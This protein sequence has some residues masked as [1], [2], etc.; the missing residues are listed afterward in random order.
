MSLQLTDNLWELKLDSTLD[1]NIARHSLGSFTNPF[2]VCYVTSDSAL[3]VWKQAGT[4]GQAIDFDDSFAHGEIKQ[5]TLNSHLLFQFPLL[6]GDSYELYYFSLP[7]LVEVKLK[8]WQ[9]LGDT[10]DTSIQQIITALESANL[11]NL[12]IN[13]P[14]I[15]IQLQQL[16]A[17]T[18]YLQ[19]LIKCSNDLDGDTSG[20]NLPISLNNDTGRLE[21]THE[22]ETKTVAI[23][24]DSKGN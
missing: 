15:E 10:T 20:V 3:P 14:E 12:Q 7:R 4:I 18:N 8:I 22:S 1:A 5:I 11:S 24:A 6:S 9:Y 19:E 23:L 17:S 13:L 21:Y 16:Q 2:V